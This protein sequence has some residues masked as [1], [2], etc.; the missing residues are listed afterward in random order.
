MLFF[1]AENGKVIFHAA[2]KQNKS[3][4]KFEET[5]KI[6]EVKLSLHCRKYLSL[7]AYVYQVLRVID[8]IRSFQA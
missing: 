5:L 2:A 6:D 4:S 7:R 3:Q 1:K 8:S